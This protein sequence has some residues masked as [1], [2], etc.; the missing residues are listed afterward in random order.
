MF[1]LAWIFSQSFSLRTPLC[2]MLITGYSCCVSLRMFRPKTRRP[3]AEAGFNKEK[4]RPDFLPL[5][6]ILSPLPPRHLPLRLLHC[7]LNRPPPYHP[8]LLPYLY[9]LGP[10]A[11]LPFHSLSPAFA[12][13]PFLAN[14]CLLA[15]SLPPPDVSREAR[16]ATL[17]LA[18]SAL[19]SLAPA[20]L[21]RLPLSLLPSRQPTR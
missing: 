11:H 14:S 21:P 5:L 19:I 3:R 20:A 1:G 18:F 9:P 17:P 6:S 7:L 8:P 2:P 4:G 16:V 13:P 15:L 10:T 12:V